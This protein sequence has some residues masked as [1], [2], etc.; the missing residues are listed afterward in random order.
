MQTVV[1]IQSDPII[2]NSIQSIALPDIVVPP[3][4]PPVTIN[5][6]QT[7]SNKRRRETTAQDN[8]LGP[9]AKRNTF[10]RQQME[11]PGSVIRNSRRDDDSNVYNYFDL[12]RDK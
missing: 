1:E 5:R 7:S 12:G 3:D 9:T 8:P 10:R 4:I 11:N 6:N 2:T